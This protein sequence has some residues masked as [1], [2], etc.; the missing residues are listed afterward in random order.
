MA[1]SGVEHQVDQH[2]LKGLG[3]GAERA[4]VRGELALD[5][6][7]LQP[8][9]ER[10]HVQGV[11]DRLV[12]P[13][14]LPGRLVGVGVGGHLLDDLVNPADLRAQGGQPRARA[15]ACAHELEQAVHARQGIGDLVRHAGGHLAQ[16]DH[17]FLLDHG[18]LLGA[19]AG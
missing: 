3:H 7:L 19:Q 2:L 10:Q 9:V 1:S 15:R 16:G 17:L 5:L 13:Q 11:L 6:H 14:R 4:G 18:A 8:A 12:K